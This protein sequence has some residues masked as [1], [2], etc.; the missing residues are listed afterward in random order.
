[1]SLEQIY[2]VGQTIA[3]LS[4]VASLVFVGLQVR[5]TSKAVKNATAQ[6]VNDNYAQWYLTLS[7]ND[8]A[9]ATSLKAAKNFEGLSDGERAQFSTLMMAL[10]CHTQNAFYQWSS[11]AL[12]SELWRGWETVLTNLMNQKAGQELWRERHY[13]FGDEFQV[14][15]QQ[16]MA[17]P[18]HPDA[19][20]FG[21]VPIM[22]FENEDIEND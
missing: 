6:A 1:M 10:L 5:S 14:K 17:A 20:V 4:I 11:G 2:F 8:T 15:V 7:T 12:S 21:T 9:L 18:T 19:N 16:V 22:P 3:A 13:L